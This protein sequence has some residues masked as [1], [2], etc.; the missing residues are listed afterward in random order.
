MH[1]QN[2]IKGSN[3][4]PQVVLVLR[5]LRTRSHMGQQCYLCR[6]QQAT[7]LI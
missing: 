6:L 1:G 4:W 2:N 3:N 7:V 5:G